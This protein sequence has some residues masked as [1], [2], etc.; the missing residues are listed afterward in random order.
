MNEMN[1]RENSIPQQR[2]TEPETSKYTAM[3]RSW[4]RLKRMKGGGPAYIRIGRAI[5]YDIRD[6]DAWLSAH[7]VEG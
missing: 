4:L 7:R 6:L 2:L 5:R 1:D 3:S